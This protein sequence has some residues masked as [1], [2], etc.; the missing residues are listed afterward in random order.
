MLVHVQEARAELAPW[1]A[2]ITNTTGHRSV[3]ESE[4]RLLSQKQDTVKQRL[5]VGN[6]LCAL[7]HLD[8]HS[9]VLPPQD[10][11]EAASRAAEGVAPSSERV[12]RLEREL[13]EHR[14]ASLL[15]V[16]GQ[17]QA[18][19]QLQMQNGSQGAGQQNGQRS[20]AGHIPGQ[21]PAGGEKE[22]SAALPQPQ[23]L[24]E[25]VPPTT[26]RPVVMWSSAGTRPAHGSRS[27][28]CSRRCWQH[29]PVA[30][31]VACMDAWVR[32]RPAGSARH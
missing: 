8:V 2:R 15:S 26:C 29:R 14:S 13:Q 9:P 10:A 5:Q 11:E 17:A 28:L 1:E 24:T 19:E 7:P 22:L 23:G 30:A 4:L 12:Q 16:R 21:L 6:V 25:V 20:A 18:A 32:R 31:Y 27:P 3:A